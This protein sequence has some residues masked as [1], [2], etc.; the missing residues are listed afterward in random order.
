MYQA[1]FT[2][3]E[4]SRAMSAVILYLTPNMPPHHDSCSKLS[5]PP[6]TLTC[7]D[8]PVTQV[9]KVAI[10]FDRRT[11]ANLLHV[12]IIWK[13]ARSPPSSG[14]GTS[15]LRPA[16]ITSLVPSQFT[17][18]SGTLR[19][20]LRAHSLT[21]RVPDPILA[22]TLLKPLLAH[23]PQVPDIALTAPRNV[24]AQNTAPRI[25]RQTR[26]RGP[27]PRPLFITSSAEDLKLRPAAA[28]PPLSVRQSR[29]SLKISLFGA[30]NR[31]LIFFRDN[32]MRAPGFVSWLATS[33]RQ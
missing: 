9:G 22:T 8:I 32:S 25:P 21:Y 23:T 24:H 28:L 33:A 16:S 19:L 1:F 30:Q 10:Q 11:C 6:P 5:C 2:G 31:L 4:N 14:T 17:R 20:I 29:P 3:I 15:L 12:S 7:I 18:T 27:P 13:R 26:S